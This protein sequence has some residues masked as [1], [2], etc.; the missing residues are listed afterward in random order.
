MEYDSDGLL[1]VE[2]YAGSFHFF[3][4]VYSPCTSLCSSQINANFIVWVSS[5][6]NYKGTVII[7]KNVKTKH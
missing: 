5:Q 1:A 3:P 4:S 6:G 2:L 7:M